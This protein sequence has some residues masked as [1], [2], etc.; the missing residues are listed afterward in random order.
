MRQNDFGKLRIGV[1]TPIYILM[2]GLLAIQIASPLRIDLMVSL[3][4]RM[5][6]GSTILAFILSVKL[7]K[8][9]DVYFLTIILLM[10][11][12]VLSMIVSMNLSYKG[13]VAALS[14][15]EIPLF[16]EAYP[17]INS[18]NIKKTIYISFTILS[19]YYNLISFT[20]LSHIY[21]TD[22]GERF[23]DFLS[24]GYNNP[25][26]TAMYLFLC[27]IILVAFHSEVKNKV[28]KIFL[29]I[30]IILIVRL[31]WLTL[32]RTG[33]ILSSV[34]IFLVIL[35][36]NKKIPNFLRIIATALPLIFLILTIFF[37]Q[38]LSNWTL[39]GDTFETGR[40]DIYIEV[41]KNLNLIQLFVG[42]YNYYFKNLH[43]A[44]CSI[45]ATTGILGVSIYYW[46]MISKI[47]YIHNSILDNKIGKIGLIGILCIYTYTSTEAAFFISGGSFAAFVISIYLLI[48]SSFHVSEKKDENL[49]HEN[50]ILSNT[51]E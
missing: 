38:F 8:N 47:R 15:L 22:Y 46:F 18:Q 3:G 21:Y 10:I 1:E 24:L 44:I 32:S 50:N 42:D 17:K 37:N 25:N 35:L 29:T 51:G 7:R 13:I 45:F 49:Y 12:V 2:F 19:I 5:I 28:A 20:S 40:Y 26:E 34:F 6:F 23:M 33:L 48:V 30:D 36:Q 4:T 31:I 41:I 27:T 43:N 11:I 9:R 14:F 16:M 39:F